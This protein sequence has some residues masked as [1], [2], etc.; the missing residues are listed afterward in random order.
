M[1]ICPICGKKIIRSGSNWVL[2]GDTLVHKKCPKDTKP[3]LTKEESQDLLSLK[4]RISYW[5]ETKPKGYVAETG[6]NF[7]RV[8][9]QIKSLKDQGYSYKDQLYALDE[10]VKK[11]GGFYGYTAVV[12]SISGT[13][14]KKN[15][16]D[17]ALEKSKASKQTAIGFDLGKLLSGEDDW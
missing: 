12:N 16:R 8:G 10:I 1:D 3:K 9:K 5:L 14:A 4:N 17:R 7:M 2:N 15:E 13:M 6:L 11:Q